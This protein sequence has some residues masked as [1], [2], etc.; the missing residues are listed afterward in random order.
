MDEALQGLLASLQARGAW[1]WR[2]WT[3]A[4][5]PL[6][7]AGDFILEVLR[8]YH[9]DDCLTYAAS[10]SFFLTIS[11]IP[12]ATLFFKLL[13][14]MLGSGAYSAQ[15]QKA[16]GEMYP[17]L[18]QGFILDTIAH[19][20]RIG[21]IGPSWVVLFIG[22]H[23]GV[24]QL[25][26]SLAH[27][28]GLRMR[29]HRQTRRFNWFRRLGVVFVGLL[30]LVILLAAGFEWGLRRRA[31]FSPILLY[32]F[33]PP[34]LALLLITLVLQHIPRRHI[35]FRHA[36]LGAAVTTGLWWGAQRVFGY[37]LAHTPTWGILYGSLGSL[38]AALIFLYYSCAIFML[39][40]EI[41]AAFYR[42]GGG[43]SGQ[44]PPSRWRR[45]RPGQRSS[46]SAG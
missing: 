25:D 31:P 24:N 44:A 13:V 9:H 10:L 8:K 32:A 1:I 18:P 6:G 28:F 7:T 43:E 17:Y 16:I 42:H 37:Y 12:L 35:R 21:S 14:L 33:L 20:R 30:F 4:W 45:R 40:A 36:L 27:I 38:M 22:A 15:L 2:R 5:P 26:R 3:R 29:Q 39:G 46:N 19:S 23:W 34:V 41:T 11:L